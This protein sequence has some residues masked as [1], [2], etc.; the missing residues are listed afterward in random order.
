MRLNTAI[1]YDIENLIGGYNNEQLLKNLSL[2]E[3]LNAVI[4]EEGVDGLSIQKAYANWGNS[5]LKTLRHEISKLGIEPVQMFGFGAGP[6][7]NASDIQIAADAIE[8]AFTKKHI[9]TFIIV[10]GDGGFS[11]VANKLHSYGKKVI[12]CAYKQVTNDIFKAVTDQFIW[13]SN[14]GLEQATDGEEPSEKTKP[15]IV[16][17]PIYVH[18][19]RPSAIVN[20]YKKAYN[21]I[22][23]PTI[24][25]QAREIHQAI[26]FIEDNETAQAYLFSDGLVI[27][28]VNEMLLYRL[29]G[30]EYKKIQKGNFP[31][32]I[33]TATQ[34]SSM[35]LVKAKSDNPDY[36]LLD[37]TRFNEEQ[38]EEVVYT[39]PEE[40]EHSSTETEVERKATVTTYRNYLKS[41]IPGYQ[42]Y[43]LLTLTK[44]INYLSEYQE[45]LTERAYRDWVVLLKSKFEKMTTRQIEDTLSS[46]IS[47]GCLVSYSPNLMYKEKEY[48][49][50]KGTA[51]GALSTVIN[52]M[53]GTIEKQFGEVD[54][55]IFRLVMD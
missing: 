2:E 16:H 23:K 31:N 55:N 8:V 41:G 52:A 15:E 33:A 39:P 40:S 34:D 48:T 10:S 14:A 53:R 1:F 27:S 25:E 46:L 49:F 24:E 47:S 26:K 44:V 9:D 45:I 17:A 13:I 38:W 5:R 11:Y 20:A 29:K 35:M 54:D 43:S 4:A 6:S 7:K 36:K 42:Q 3:I 28:I 30:F 22:R 32:F 37:R 12:G 51:D 19:E 50:I 21:P 18:R